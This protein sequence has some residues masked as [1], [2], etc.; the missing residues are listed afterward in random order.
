MSRLVIVV[1]A[2]GA[3]KSFFLKAWKNALAKK[4]KNVVRVKKRVTKEREPRLNEIK[5]GE[6][7]LIFSSEYDPSTS[8]GSAWYKKTYPNLDITT[9]KVGE[10]EF[11]NEALGHKKFTYLYEDAFYSVDIDTIDNALK[12]RQIPIVIVRKCETILELLKRYDTALVIYTQSILS[13][14]DL[15]DKL[16]NLGEEREIAEERQKRNTDTLMEY[17]NNIHQLHTRSSPVCVVI[18]NYDESAIAE[19]IGVIYKTEIEAFEFQTKSVFV[20]QSYANEKEATNNFQMIKAGVESAF[21]AGTRVDRAN[22]RVG[23]A[24]SIDKHVWTSIDCSDYIICDITNDRCDD[25][26]H[27]KARNTRQGTSANVWLELGYALA[28][29]RQRGRDV[30]ERIIIVTKVNDHTSR[31]EI[32]VDLGARSII[33]REYRD[34]ATLQNLICEELEGIINPDKESQI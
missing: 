26:V 11:H 17:I 5:T 2:G 27:D 28:K 4:N 34:Q 33:L 1:G 13:G 32:P 6:S 30:E 22:L 16:I 21:G 7:D 19:Q 10:L 9:T 18:N 29:I 20:I 15:V 25:C 14:N 31:T 24:Y 12:Q 8:K 3:G 23:G